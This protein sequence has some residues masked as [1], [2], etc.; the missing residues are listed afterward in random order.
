[1][2]G[3]KKIMDRNKKLE[4]KIKITCSSCGRTDY[5]KIK[6]NYCAFCGKKINDKDNRNK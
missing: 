5:Y 4:K 2:E 3:E 1:M 6:P